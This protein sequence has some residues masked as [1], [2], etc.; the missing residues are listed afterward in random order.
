VSDGRI[1]GMEALVRW[2]PPGADLVAPGRFIAAAEQSGL[3]IPIGQWVLNEACRQAVKWRKAGLP[4]LVVSVNLSVVQ[5]RRSNILHD[6]TTALRDSGLPAELLELELTE[7]VL[8]HDTEAALETLRALKKIGVR[9]AIDDFGTGY[10]SLSYVK[11]L[12][13]HK[14]KI[15]RSFVSGL[16][17]GLEDAAIVRAI[18]QLGQSLQLEV[19]AEGVETNAQLDFLSASGCDQIQ[20]FRVSRPL[21]PVEFSRLFPPGVWRPGS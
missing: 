18:I 8:L 5:F 4:D 17:N 2:Q 11:S 6:V 3:I 10:C 13:V 1:I 20:G 16:G 15:D 19:V 12:P 9:L 14:L 7:S 21:P